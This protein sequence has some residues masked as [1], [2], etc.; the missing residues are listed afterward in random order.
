MAVGLR[1]HGLLCFGLQGL[2]A[3][4]LGA[5]KLESLMEPGLLAGATACAEGTA[6]LGVGNASRA[7]QVLDAVLDAGEVLVEHLVASYQVLQGCQ[8]LGN[9][10][11]PGPQIPNT[12]P[13]GKV[14]GIS[15]VVFVPGGLATLYN[16]Q[17]VDMVGE[18][19]VKPLT[20]RPLFDA[21][22]PP[23]RDGL[24]ELDQR[25]LVGWQDRFPLPLPFLLT[26]TK[27][28]L[29]LCPS[30]PIKWFMEFL[31][32]GGWGFGWFWMSKP[33]FS[34]AGKNSIV[35]FVIGSHHNVGAW[36]TLDCNPGEEVTCLGPT[37]Y[38]SS[39]RDALLL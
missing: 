22:M 11:D 24:D 8:G 30:N 10:P 36:L 34:I 5:Q 31:L 28:Q 12:E 15:F 29:L 20:L 35:F 38:E 4:L 3:L 27:V 23:A 6:G 18:D 21:Q 32:S 14:V 16:G 2:Q 25:L 37:S 1:D 19:L 7:V 17:I 13:F 33:N 9:L 26:T 39:R